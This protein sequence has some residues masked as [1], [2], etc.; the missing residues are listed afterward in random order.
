[1][2]RKEKTIHYLYK[3]TCDITGRYYVGM[4]STDNLED[5]YMGSGKRLRYSIRKH[6]KENHTKE[7]LEFFE[8]RLLLI[9]AEKK[10]ITS[11]M[12][13]DIN[14]MNLKEGGSGGFSNK[15]HQLKCSKAGAL[16]TNKKRWID[17]RE[18][19]IEEFKIKQ[20]F[21]CQ[22]P[23]VRANIINNLV[24]G[25]KHSEETK[26]LMSEKRK[27]TG[28][29]EKNSQFGTCWVTKD[30]LNKKIKKDLLETYLN[31]GWFQG[32]R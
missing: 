2:A 19:S 13:L 25:Q 4:H 12:V 18:K 28:T 20:K 32:R 5:G 17:N 1:M 21:R 10:A 9:E 22:D 23:I 3:T 29:G 6:G 31:E 30:G 11:E 26:Q 24:Y 8:N 15:E 14:C 27:G 16:S 7:I